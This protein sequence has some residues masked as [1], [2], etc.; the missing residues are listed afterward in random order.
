VTGATAGAR[1]TG[2]ALS[3]TTA[4]HPGWLRWGSLVLCLLGLAVSAYLTYEH[5]SSSTS[6]ACPDNGAINCL[7]VTTSSYSK[8]LGIPV[9]LIGLLF[10]AG[11]TALCSPPAWAAANP[12]VGRLRLLGSVSGVVFMVYLV[13]AELF[14]VDAIC[15]W[16]TAVHVLTVLLFALLVV[17]AAIGEA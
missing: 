7:K 5:F 2:R 6:L 11:M 1:S 12:W 17:G 15:L 10:Y 9:A 4:R 13:W 16:C 3:G 8:V 14:R